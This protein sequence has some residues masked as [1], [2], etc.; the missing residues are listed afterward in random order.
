MRWRNAVRVFAYGIFG[1]YGAYLL[2]QPDVPSIIAGGASIL[3]AAYMGDISAKDGVKNIKESFI[4][5]LEKTT[6]NINIVY[7]PETAKYSRRI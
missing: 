1:T 6:D 5:S 2:T 4:N 7:V 3:V